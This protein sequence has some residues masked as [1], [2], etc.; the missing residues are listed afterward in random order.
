MWWIAAGL[1]R[2]ALCIDPNRAMSQYIRERWD[3][4][5][6]FPLGPVYAISQSGD[7]YLWIGTQAGLVRF[8]GLNFRLIRNAPGLANG[9]SVLGLMA[10]PGGRLWIRLEGSL[11]RYDNGVFQSTDV[12]VNANSS[13]MGRS[14]QGE[15]LISSAPAGILAYRRGKFE[16]IADALHLPPSPVLSLAASK[17]GSIWCGT[18]GAG[19]FRLAGGKAT[20]VSEGLPD[21][22]VNS[23]LSGKQGDLWIGT[24]NGVAYWNGSRLTPLG[25]SLHNVQ[26]LVMVRDRDG[27]IWAGTDS[28]G[29]VRINEHGLAYLDAAGEQSPNAVTALFEDR[30]G[31]LWI[32]SAAGI[33]RLRDSAFVTYSQPEGLPTDGSNPLYVDEDN[34]LW[35]APVT[36]G[37]WWM[38]GGRH[39]QISLDG[40]QRDIVYSIGGRNGDL[41]LGRQRGGLTKLA[42]EGDRVTAKT[43]T[44]AD[45]LPQNSIFSVYESRDGAVWAGTL[46]GGV[47]Q[48]KDGRFTIYTRA[49][50]LLSNTVVGIVQGSDG[51]MWFATPGG[52]NRLF[53]G[54]LDS[55]T[56][57]N[58]LPSENIYCL[59]EDSAGILWI[60]TAGGLAFRDSKGIERAVGSP[61]WL[62]EPI[63]G[64]EEDRQGSLWLATSSHVVRVSL[65]K[66]LHG[67][68]SEGDWREYGIADGL[69]GV[70]GVKRQRSVVRDPA[71]RIWFSLNRGI[72]VVDPSR[73]T[74]DVA[75]AIVQVQGISVDGVAVPMAGPIRIAGGHQRIRFSYAGLSLAVP[76]RIRFRYRLDGY[77]SNWSESTALREAAYTNLPPRRYRFRVVA[78]NPDGVWNGAEASVGFEVDPLFWQSWWFV[79]ASLLAGG[80]AISG[81]FYFRMRQLTARL[82][83]RFEERLMERTRIAQILHDTLL[84]G[85]LSASMQVHVAADTLP[86]DSRAKAL[87]NRALQLMSQVT[88]E[89][90]NAV[91]GLR[92]SGSMSLDLEQALSLVRDDHVAQVQA[93]RGVDFRV[94]VEGQ[95]RQLHPLLRDD[96]YRIGREALLNAF[97]HSRAKRIEV[98]LH[99]SAS[100]LRVVVRDDGC[101]IDPVILKSGRDGHWGLPGMRE[102]AEQIGASLQVFSSATVGTEVRLAVPGHIAFQARPGEKIWQFRRKA[103]DEAAV[104]EQSRVEGKDE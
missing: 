100:Q 96:L 92:S 63:L 49:E 31:N 16:A 77:D 86:E 66:L 9:A 99:Y 50:G 4:D 20:S 38:K 5:R 51:A 26:V 2:D 53:N 36:G 93:A 87:L 58:G 69:R 78:S 104:P 32:G 97:R 81:F 83:L 64:F 68:L 59:L 15:L 82:N 37:L 94:I 19:L 18:R 41:W 14:E 43:F 6:G 61:D 65:Q 85:F 30:E 29:L 28:R 74:R 13:A 88:D 56:A 60:G 89:G 27:N 40:L 55:F 98:E 23:L 7:G 73:L 45:G 84:Q 75:P 101:G 10:E 102:R 25:D 52:L 8:D 3:S 39:G 76:E 103:K 24:D 54:H 62:R 34:R 11:L 91:R 1:P 80:C 35:F 95:K 42:I 22:K 71:G 72:S 33:E 48:L 44:E 12:V 90:R 70:E 67:T 46:S 57:E 47:S 17:D 21:S 79:A